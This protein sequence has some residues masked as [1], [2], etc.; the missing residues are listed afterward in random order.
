MPRR[1]N[2]LIISSL[3]TGIRPFFVE[4]KKEFKGMPAFTSTF[5]SLLE[6]EKVDKVYILFFGKGIITRY[7]L[8]KEYQDKIEARGFSY[9]GGVSGLWST[10]ALCF[11]AIRLI[12]VKKIKVIY[13]HGPASGLA[14]IV[15][16]LTTK[17][18]VRRIYGTF[19]ARKLNLSKWHIFLSHPLEYL[20][21]ALPAKALVITNDGTKGNLVFDKI[22]NRKTPLYFWLNGINKDY[23]SILPIKDVIKKYN[24]RFVPEVCYIAR[25]DK[26]KR[27]HLL[28]EIL[29]E[30]KKAG[31]DV[32]VLIAG[33]VINHSYYEELKNRITVNGLIDNI[34]LIPGVTKQESISIIKHAKLSVSLYDHSNLGNVFLES[35]SLGTPMF[36]KT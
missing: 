1:N 34:I 19:L 29:S 36:Q 25:I 22:G 3:W 17:P 27:Q 21:F 16:L 30:A 10:L 24:V 28:I 13:G 33:P 35:L 6:D 11:H 12:L 32:K 18:N 5:F 4:S 20:A 31:N 14:G 9:L 23:G 26:W 8:P 15:S 2:I 7:S